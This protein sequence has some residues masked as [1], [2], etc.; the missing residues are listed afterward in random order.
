LAG[1]TAATVL[2]SALPILV[3]PPAQAYWYDCEVYLRNVGYTVGPKVREACGYDN[4]FVESIC[5][6]LLYQAGVKERDYYT[7]CHEAARR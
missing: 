6:A 3:A 1:L 7:A 5:Q 4:Q 2:A